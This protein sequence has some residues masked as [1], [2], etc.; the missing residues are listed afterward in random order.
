M[1]FKLNNSKFFMLKNKKNKKQH[2]LIIIFLYFTFFNNTYIWLIK[3]MNIK[4]FIIISSYLLIYK[5][6][7]LHVWKISNTKNTLNNF[8]CFL[9]YKW[10]HKIINN[11]LLFFLNINKISNVYKEKIP[12]IHFIKCITYALTIMILLSK[13]LT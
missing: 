2:I 13:D 4:L 5:L 6:N 10:E 7:N 9:L 1:L 3:I 11:N 8:K 12:T